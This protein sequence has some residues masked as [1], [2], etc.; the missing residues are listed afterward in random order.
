MEEPPVLSRQRMG[1]VCVWTMGK[2]AETESFCAISDSR[3]LWVV[4]EDLMVA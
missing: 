1:G 2:S 3:S 4:S